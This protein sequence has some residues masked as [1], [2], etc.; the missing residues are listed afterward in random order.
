MLRPKRSRRKLKSASARSVRRARRSIDTIS[1]CKKRTSEVVHEPERQSP[2]R[3][4][5]VDTALIGIAQVRVDVLAGGR[6]ALD[7]D[8]ERGVRERHPGHASPAM[9]DHVADVLDVD[10][11]LRVMVTA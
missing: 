6:I 9:V 10:D 8:G 3:R 11:K 1:L 4:Q 7:I 5:R 2:H